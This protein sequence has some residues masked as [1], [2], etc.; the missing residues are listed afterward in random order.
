M[1]MRL[2]SAAARVAVAPVAAALALAGCSGG[3]SLA[4]SSHQN[5][6]AQVASAGRASAVL[7]ALHAGLV[8]R[9]VTGTS[10]YLSLGDSLSLGV[11]PA[12]TGQDV[13]TSR[14]Y[15]DR[16]AA[17]LR[18]KLPHL[19]LVKLGC[20]GETTATMI[21]GGICPYPA[22]SQLDEA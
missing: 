12:R 9:A 20:S 18:A 19:R 1:R 2:R 6:S 21:H 4:S 13:A 11:Q 16:L 14:G 22:G 17:M 3:G 15:P 10:Y 5:G 8:R 7:A